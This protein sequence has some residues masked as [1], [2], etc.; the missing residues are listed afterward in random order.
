MSRQATL[1]TTAFLCLLVMQAWLVYRVETAP[2][3][4]GRPVTQVDKQAAPAALL[5]ES[6]INNN[7]V[8]LAQINARLSALESP[9][10][11]TAKSALVEQPA[12]ATLDGAEAVAADRKL[13]AMLPAEAMTH[14]ELM[15]FQAQLGQL[16]ELERHQLSAA[17]ARAINSGRVQPKIK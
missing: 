8:L 13:A 11:S 14:E 10:L 4:T 7:A 12:S 9:G 16:P 17:L 1:Q 3:Y 6:N 15:L 2:A 5:G